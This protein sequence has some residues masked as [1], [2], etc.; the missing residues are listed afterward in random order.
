MLEEV[1]AIRLAFESIG[2]IQESAT[3]A[4]FGVS[5]NLDTSSSESESDDGT[6]EFS[7]P[8][9]SEVTVSFSRDDIL[10]LLKAGQ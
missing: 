6:G 9:H 5:S 10:T 1:K 7:N 4:Q 3:L 8:M 2:N